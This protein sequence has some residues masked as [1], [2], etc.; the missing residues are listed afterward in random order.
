MSTNIAGVGLNYMCNPYGYCPDIT[1]YDPTY[2]SY[3]GCEYNLGMGGSIFG[4]A[5]PMPMPGLGM[6]IDQNYFNQMKDYQR[7][8]T[9]Y[10]VDQQR[11]NRNA[12]LR[13]NGSM[14]AIQTTFNAL[15]DKIT[16]NE[17]SQVEEAYN[18]FVA[19][20]G[21]AYGNASTQEIKA[22]AATIYAQ[23]NGGKTIAQDLRE[24]GH[25]SFVQGL[26]HGGT[27]GLY[28]AD[29]T[30][31]NISKIT[32]A[33]V[34]TGDKAAQN[35]GR[36]VGV[37]ALGGIAYGIA[38]ACEAGAKAGATATKSSKSVL[39]GA[40]VA[41]VAALITFITGKVTT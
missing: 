25:S 39:V 9:D 40:V 30:E 10:N 2:T 4:G 7:F 41:G 19:A 18:N 35:L 21:S 14:E 28:D 3:P 27:F 12:D 20:V 37:G 33:P 24:N 38:K 32:G 36:V 5:C 17:Q 31:D 22:R 1:D 29:S 8:Y 26:I 16:T 15:K 6:G 23:L 11:M 34:G 13:I